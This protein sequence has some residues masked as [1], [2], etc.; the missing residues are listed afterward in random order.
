MR[1]FTQNTQCPN[2]SRKLSRNISTRVTLNYNPKFRRQV[3]LV[4]LPGVS[5]IAVFTTAARLQGRKSG[6]TACPIRVE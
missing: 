5:G 2:Q 3:G 4:S 1:L 6:K